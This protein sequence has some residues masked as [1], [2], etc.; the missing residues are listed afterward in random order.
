MTEFTDEQR[1][2]QAMV[3]DFARTRLAPQ[4]LQRAHDAEYP[5]EAAQ[6]MAEVPAGP[7]DWRL[8]QV[9]TEQGVVRCSV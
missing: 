5:W 3:R 8:G 1:E 4:A 9:A 7:L 2:F 6:E